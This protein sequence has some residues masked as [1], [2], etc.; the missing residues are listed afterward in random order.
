MRCTDDNYDE[1]LE[2]VL[3]VNHPY[4]YALLKSDL[5]ENMKKRPWTVKRQSLINDEHTIMNKKVRDGIRW[6][7]P[8]FY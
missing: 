5:K 6:R 3:K 7:G 1:F 4:E 8:Y 2:K